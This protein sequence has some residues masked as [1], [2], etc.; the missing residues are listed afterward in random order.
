MLTSRFD[1][2]TAWHVI[3]HV[4]S[5][6]ETLCEWQRVLR[7]GGLLVTET[8][9]TTCLKVRLLGPKYKRYWKAEHIYAFKRKNYEPF[10][11]DAG[12]EILPYPLLG[13]LRDLGLPMAS[14]AVG[15]QASKGLRR[16]LGLGKAFQVFA[17]KPTRD[18]DVKPLRRAA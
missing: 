8:P 6:R 13:R 12:L 1:V 14:Y 10:I 5:I 9:D 7:P 15:Y 11:R 16:I 18:A 17:R 3:E 4:A 2:V